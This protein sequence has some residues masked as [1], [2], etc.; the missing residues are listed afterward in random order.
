MLFSRKNITTITHS[1]V[2]KMSQRIRIYEVQEYIGELNYI[3]SLG[4]VKPGK[5]S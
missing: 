3:L 5:S 2:M 1:Q 4:K